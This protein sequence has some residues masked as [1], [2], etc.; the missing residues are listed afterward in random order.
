MTLTNRFLWVLLLISIVLIGNGGKS[1]AKRRSG[2]VRSRYADE[3]PNPTRD[4]EFDWQLIKN[5]FS[6]DRTNAALST[7]LVK[8]LLNMLYEGT[9]TFSQ[10]Q[11]ELSGPLGRT[12][13]NYDSPKCVEI[14]NTLQGSS[15]RLHI[16]SRVFADQQISVTQKYAST[17]G[18]YYNASVVSVDF[19]QPQQAANDI[20]NWV[21]N[22]T[23]GQIRELVTTRDIQGSI[24]LLASTIY[25]K[26]LWRNVFPEAATMIQP[27]KTGD[28]R[29]VD[30]PSMKQIQNLYFSESSQL[31]AKLLRL[32]YEEGRFTMILLLPNED[33]NINELVNALSGEAIHQAIRDM[34][35][36][37]VKVQLPRFQIDYSSSMKEAL[38][39]LGIDRIFTD[40]AELSGIARGSSLPVKVSDLFQKTVIVVDEKGSTASSAAGSSLVYTIASDPEKFIID[41]PFLFFIEEES[42]GT[43]LFAGKVEDPMQ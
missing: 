14:M 15:K 38:Q 27:F 20:N 9:G 29:T 35:D 2:V 4:D 22:G 25:F 19:Q 33:S 12:P 28:G 36:I 39:Q 30:V 26:G 31:K 42:T 1:L 16:A 10:T 5:T 13:G 7:F 34:E 41:R 32:P 21:S 8:Y 18:M 6:K 17:V 37:E 40:G 43:L 11:R 3:E 24:M 23:Q